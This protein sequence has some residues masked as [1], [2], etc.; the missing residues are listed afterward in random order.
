MI[1]PPSQNDQVFEL[2]QKYIKHDDVIA[3]RNLLDAGMSPNL[4]NQHGFTLLIL[5]AQEGNTT[6]GELLLSRG[7]DP[8]L[9]TDHGAASLTP[10][11]HA[12]ANGRVS[13]VKLLL[14]HGANPDPNLEN[15]LPR[16]LRDPRQS[17]HIIAAT[18]DALRRRS[19]N[20]PDQLAYEPNGVTGVERYSREWRK[21][22][23]IRWILALL[24][25]AYLPGMAALSL[26]FPAVPGWYFFFRVGCRDLSHYPYRNVISVPQVREYVHQHKLL[27]KPIH[28]KMPSLRCS[29]R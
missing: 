7:A 6:I 19:D 11:G 2:A 16:F 15:W 22:R 9:G 25:L 23:T 18:R 29:R 28:Q 10:F 27:G 14:N 12:A 20:G 5:V 3:I 26:L 24:F 17:E 4:A 21:L 1:K 8:N 13:F